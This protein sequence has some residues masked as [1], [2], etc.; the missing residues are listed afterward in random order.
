MLPFDNDDTKKEGAEFTYNNQFGF[1]PVF[2]HLGWGWMVNA[3]LRPGSAHSL[4]PGTKDFIF[5]SL[6]YGKSMIQDPL[7]LVMD[8][9]FGSQEV[10]LDLIN[11]DRVDFI[12]KHNLRQESEE[13]W[14]ETA[15]ANCQEME[16]FDTRQTSQNVYPGPRL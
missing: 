4:A 3:R 15:K 13:E 6:Q 16:S 1:N 8:S 11:A 10:I 12:V 14:L 2:A 5:Q 7:L 9:G